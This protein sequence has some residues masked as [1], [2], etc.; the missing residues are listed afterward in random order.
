MRQLATIQKIEELRPI[1]GADAIECAR[2]LGWE[3]VVKKGQFKV[4]DLCVYCEIDSILPADNPHFAFLEGKRIKTVKLRGQISQGI[5]FG[6]EVLP[7]LEEFYHDGVDP[8]GTDCTEHL[9]VTKWEPVQT[10]AGGQPKGNFPEYIPKT[11]ETRVQI[12]QPLLDQFAG[13]RC[14]ITEKLDG[15]SIT[16]WRL[17]GELHVA[18][19]NLQMKSGT[20]WDVAQMYAEHVEEGFALQ[21]ELIGPG[22]QKNKYKLKEHHVRFFSKFNIPEQQYV[23]P[24][25]Y[26]PYVPIIQENYILGT[27]IPDLVKLAIGQSLI[28]SGTK[29]EGIVIRSYENIGGV[30]SRHF[31]G[32][33]RL[34][35]AM[36]YLSF[37]VINPE[38]SLKYDE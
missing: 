28:T 13:T 37:K 30:P 25:T 31:F 7:S 5:A 17:D 12:L 1:E 32:G 26:G 19:R 29:R 8:V 24:P 14:Y 18:S 33:G 16:I 21:G 22:V 11:D 4:G 23:L 34:N 36:G 15:S 9:K 3:L 10:M 2:V 27:S 38:F 6:L 20:F 35:N